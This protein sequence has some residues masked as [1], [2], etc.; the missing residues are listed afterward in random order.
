MTY[1]VAETGIATAQPVELY[2]WTHAAESYRYTSA[3]ADQV[4]S[5]QVYTAAPLSR[6]AISQGEEIARAALEVTVPQDHPVALL[7]SLGPPVDRVL[8]TLRRRHATDA[9]AEAV[10]IWQGRVLSCEWSGVSALLRHEPVWTALRRSGLR[11]T[12]GLQCPHLLGS[13]G[14]GVD[15]AD[16]QAAG[17]VAAVSGVAVQVAAAAGQADGYWYGGMLES[18]QP[19]T[20]RTLRAMILGHTGD[21]LTLHI[22]LA[23]VPGDAVTLTPGCD[24][25][26][27][28]AGG[29]V[30]R[31]DNA[32]NFGGFPWTP[33]TSPYGGTAVY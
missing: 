4:L 26:L 1:A 6:G 17:T 5:T 19:A 2:R 12:W 7:F 11:R 18:Y 8:L 25:S 15:L 30:A 33:Q 21:D 27:D 28:G 22:P 9:D 3:Q 10:V 13:T 20:G 23:L 24:H 16:F 29:C 14:C 31:F 32:V